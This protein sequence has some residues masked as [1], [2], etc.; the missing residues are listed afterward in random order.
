MQPILYQSTDTDAPILSG[1][2]GSLNAL[3]LACLVN[4]Y[5][6]KAPATWSAPYTNAPTE[7]TVFRP[8]AGPRPYLQVQDNGPGA[9]SFKEARLRGYASM[10]A[11]NTGTDPFPSA[12][13]ATNGLFVRKSAALSSTA[14][15]WRLI[16]DD[17]TF[18]LFIDCGDNAGYFDPYLF[19]AYESWKNADQ[20][21]SL[22]AARTTENINQHAT[23]YAIGLNYQTPGTSTTFAYTPRS[24]TGV[25]TSQILSASLNNA[26]L[27]TYTA[28]IIGSAGQQY[29]HPVDA[30]LLL[31]PI[32]LT[33]TNVT[34]GRLRGLWAPCHARPILD[35]DTFSVLDGA[36]TREFL[37]QNIIANG[38]YAIETSNTWDA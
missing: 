1:T 30:S 37:A 25:G 16:A 10:S 21:A 27:Q 28:A 24:Y 23:P 38:Q 32:L 8:A 5:G 35:Q 19:G 9:G 34:R 6:S 2:T 29:P 15:T 33:E 17:Q 4:G 7:T 14:V 26:I 11:Y 36:I 13:Q 22:I 18:Y 31:S 3:L 12:A 20:W